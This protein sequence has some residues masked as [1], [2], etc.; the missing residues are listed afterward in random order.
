ME[1]TLG[2][3]AP[4]TLLKGKGLT[5]L[6]QTVVVLGREDEVFFGC[7]VCT[8]KLVSS[9]CA[10]QSTHCTYTAKL[11][12]TNL[13]GSVHTVQSTVFQKFNFQKLNF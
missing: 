8:T 4:S 6:F 10:V 3:R 11:L 12:E 1:G 5:V 2:L 7:T 9:I 13:E